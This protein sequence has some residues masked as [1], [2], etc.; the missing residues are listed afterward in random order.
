[1]NASEQ[2]RVNYLQLIGDGLIF[3]P[4]NQKLHAGIRNQLYYQDN[5]MKKYKCNCCGKLYKLSFF[6]DPSLCEDCI[7][8]DQNAPYDKEYETDVIVLRNP[9]GK[10]AAVFL[11][12]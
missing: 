2:N 4:F 6:N 8:K 3:T 5:Y 12:D 11:D 10:T 1:M 7:D 9:S